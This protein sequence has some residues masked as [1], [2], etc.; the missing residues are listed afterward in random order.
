M[1][2]FDQSCCGLALSVRHV[3]SVISEVFGWWNDVV[4]HY[5]TLVLC[6]V[7]GID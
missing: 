1:S 3:R 7:C 4:H 2:Q 6:L 5:L